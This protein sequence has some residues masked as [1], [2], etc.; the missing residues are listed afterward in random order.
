MN[1]HTR[2]L[3]ALKRNTFLVFLFFVSTFDVL[4]FCWK[5]K[6]SALADPVP[7]SCLW[8]MLCVVH[9]SEHPFS[10]DVL[11]MDVRI[12]LSGKKLPTQLL[13]A[14]GVCRL[15]EWKCICVSSLESVPG[16]A[17]HLG[18]KGHSCNPGVISAGF[19]GAAARTQH[20]GL[21]ATRQTQENQGEV[22]YASGQEIL[23]CHTNA[24]WECS[25]LGSCPLS[26]LT[27]GDLPS[28]QRRYCSRKQ[29]E[30]QRSQAQTAGRQHRGDHQEGPEVNT[31][32]LPLTEGC[33]A[34]QW[35]KRS[36]VCRRKPTP[37]SQILNS[38]RGQIAPD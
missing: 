16:A 10:E 30:R 37:C 28:L 14:M 35:G 21:G 34:P 18:S 24:R 22:L 23:W 20:S 36:A 3:E 32:C 27:E 26:Q 6:F 38:L 31:P 11:L 7:L 5:F 33:R 1:N 29:W 4:L 12:D 15:S 2:C 8:T 9:A 25:S 17:V 13:L 19:T